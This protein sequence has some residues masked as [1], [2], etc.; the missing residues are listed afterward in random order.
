MKRWRVTK[1]YS[2][3]SCSVARGLRVVCETLKRRFGTDASRRVVSVVFPAPDGDE[4]M[5]GS[6]PSFDILHLFANA[7]EL[8]LG[9]DDQ[10]RNRGIRALRTSGVELASDLLQQEIE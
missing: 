9:L 6:G 3:P 7:L 5:S 10:M 2:R 4:T 1:W 8:G